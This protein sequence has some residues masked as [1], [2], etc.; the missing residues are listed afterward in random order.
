MVRGAIKLPRAHKDTQTDFTLHLPF[1]AAALANH[2]HELPFYSA[3]NSTYKTPSAS[4]VSF[5]CT[6]N[7]RVAEQ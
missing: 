6:V 1:P 7:D 2:S 3:F 4:G 5:S